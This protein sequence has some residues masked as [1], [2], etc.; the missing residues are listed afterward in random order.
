M[1]SRRFLRRANLR[2]RVRDTACTVLGLGSADLVPLVQVGWARCT[3]PRRSD[4]RA[5]ARAHD[6][7]RS[8]V[9]A[10][11]VLGDPDACASLLSLAFASGLHAD[12]GPR[13]DLLDLDR[14]EVFDIVRRD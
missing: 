11:L 7:A 1:T 10:L 12:P 13:Q 8:A 9:R 4:L 2:A 14:A 6:R 5:R 3:S